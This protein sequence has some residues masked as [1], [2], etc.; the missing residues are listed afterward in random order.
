M[1]E[2]N[3]VFN[4]R[5]DKFDYNIYATSGALLCFGCGEVGHLV[6]VFSSMCILV[7]VH[8]HVCGRCAGSQATPGLWSQDSHDAIDPRQQSAI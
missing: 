8:F 4:E 6:Q 3:L 7:C 2:E 1:D 5:V